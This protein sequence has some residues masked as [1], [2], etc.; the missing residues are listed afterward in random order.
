LL[1]KDLLVL[2]QVGQ[3]DAIPMVRWHIAMIL[4]HLAIYEEHIDQLTSTLLGLLRDKSVF[5]KSWS[6]VSLCI[7]A[8][9]YPGENNRIIKAILPLQH[10]AS[11]AIRAR[12]KKALPVLIHKETPFPKGWVKSDQIQN[13]P[14]G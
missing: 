9:I 12:V 11:I 10:D 6:I 13:L 7:I 2:L 3:E 14:Y 5:V 1:I 4:G 8:R